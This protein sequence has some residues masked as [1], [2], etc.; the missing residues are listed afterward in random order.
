LKFEGEG[1]R[2]S[3]KVTVLFREME[4]FPAGRNQLLGKV[5]T[6][7]EVELKEGL[8]ESGSSVCFGGQQNHCFDHLAAT[9]GEW[10]QIMIECRPGAKNGTFGPA[11]Q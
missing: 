2:I 10:S 4:V 6:R 8:A 11:F 5:K 7:G 9:R 1:F 3:G